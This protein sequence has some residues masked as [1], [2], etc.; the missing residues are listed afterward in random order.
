M[1][2]VLIVDDEPS[3]LKSLQ[4][5]LRAAPCCYGGRQF[6]LEVVTAS[7]PLTALQLA[8]T[9]EFDLFV[10][11]YRM[12]EMDGIEFLKA[13]R[14]LWPDAARLILSGYADL[15]ALVRAVNEVGI[16]RFVGKPWN[17]YELMSAIGQALA[18]RQLLLE[19]RQLADLIRLEMGDKSAE[20]VEAERLERIEPGITRVNWGPDGSVILDDVTD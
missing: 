14:T 2:R 5:L 8:R 19:N 3:I 20:Q 1:S 15:N 18:H 10:S 9:Q 7:S 11:D 4:R 6:E 17:D 13:A 16:D 12:P